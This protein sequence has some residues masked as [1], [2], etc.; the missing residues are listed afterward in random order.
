ME[1]HYEILLS[2][3]TFDL[4]GMFI[5]GVDFGQTETEAYSEGLEML[6]YDSINILSNLFSIHIFLITLLLQA[7]F[8]F[9]LR[10]SCCNGPTQWRVCTICRKAKESNISENIVL[11][12]LRLFL[13]GFLEIL[14]CATIGVGVF[15]L[16]ELTNLDKLTCT[17]NIFYILCLVLFIAI[18]IWFLV[19]KSRFLINL[20]DTRDRLEQLKVLKIIEQKYSK[21]KED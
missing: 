8:A 3:V 4:F 13:T 11:G 6:D 2:V 19:S 5:D 1:T 17:V 18:V 9:I 10:F 12:S 16:S 7:L 15:S 14:I 20:K 21:E